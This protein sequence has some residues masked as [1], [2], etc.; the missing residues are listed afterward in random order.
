MWVIR[1]VF[2]LLL[3]FLLVYLFVA[4][5]GQSVDLNLFGRQYPDLG[6]FWVVAGS[7]LLGVAAVVV[8]MGLR[9]IKLR[10]ELGRQR[11]QQDSLSRELADLRALPLQE[12]TGD[13]KQKK[14]K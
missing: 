8:G 7:F 5:A 1:L 6:L 14:G 10:Q 4:N 2:F 11:R 3:L 9:E 12:L 13:A